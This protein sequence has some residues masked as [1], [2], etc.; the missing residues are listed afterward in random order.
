MSS[1]K[2]VE[3][4]FKEFNE[5]KVE[6][7]AFTNGNKAAG[8]RARKHLS[9]IKKKITPAKAAMMTKAKSIKRTK[10]SKSKK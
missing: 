5:M 9:S 3:E 7:E 8:T 2:E 6:Y 1:V 4:L 10:K